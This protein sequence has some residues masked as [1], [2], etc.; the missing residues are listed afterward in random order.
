MMATDVV[1]PFVLETHFMQVADWD[2]H[3]SLTCEYEMSGTWC[4]VR[5]LTGTP[6]RWAAL[7]QPGGGMVTKA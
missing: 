3:C 1:E 4:L 6:L 7:I 2:V 5:S